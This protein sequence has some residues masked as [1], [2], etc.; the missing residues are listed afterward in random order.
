S[1]HDALPIFVGEIIGLL[2]DII[3]IPFNFIRINMVQY[4]QWA[5][6]QV[7]DT[8]MA[9]VDWVLAK[10]TEFGTWLSELW[11]SI[12]TGIKTFF[13]WVWDGIVAYLDWAPETIRTA[14]NTC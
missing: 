12:W 14:W 3:L 4:T 8:V 2:V 1:L 13:T 7:G 5:W 9:G 10:V 11:D 6:D